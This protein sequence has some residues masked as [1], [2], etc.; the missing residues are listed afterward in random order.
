MRNRR[1]PAEVADIYRA[2]PIKRCWRKPWHINR[3]REVSARSTGNAR[4]IIDVLTDPDEDMV[5]GS[6]KFEQIFRQ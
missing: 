5:K 4:H 2:W 1:T 3:E 6:E